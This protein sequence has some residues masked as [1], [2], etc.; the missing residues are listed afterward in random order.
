MMDDDK[1]FR[2]TEVSGLVGLSRSAIYLRLQDGAFP[3]P[4]RIGRRGVRWKRSDIL[5]WIAEL[6]PTQRGDPK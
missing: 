1:L 3:T 4:V 2:M 6:Q 5:Q